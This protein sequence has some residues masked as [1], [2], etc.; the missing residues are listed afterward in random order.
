MSAELAATAAS[1]LGPVVE[2]GSKNA[3]HGKSSRAG[4]KTGSRNRGSG[5]SRSGGAGG[6][7]EGGGGGRPLSEENVVANGV[8]SV[9]SVAGAAKGKAH[10]A[11]AAALVALAPI[12]EDAASSLAEAARNVTSAAGALLQSC[13]AAL[14][15][16]ACREIFSNLLTMSYQH[17][18]SFRKSAD[19]LISCLHTTC[20]N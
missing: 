11:A 8:G 6:S 12:S 7:T 15:I 19:L 16:C 2:P 17:D 9:N 5:S 13:R 10:Q 4:G 3:K 1:A 18:S 14:L 20:A